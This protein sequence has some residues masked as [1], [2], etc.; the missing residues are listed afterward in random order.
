MSVSLVYLG[1]NDDDGEMDKMCKAIAKKLTHVGI[2]VQETNSG[3]KDL[4]SDN[5]VTYDRVWFCGHSR[6]VEATMSI[7]KNDDRTLGGFP[8][9][10]IAKFVKSCITRGKNKIRLICC[11]SAQQQR[12]RPTKVGAPPNGFAR[13]LGNELLQSVTNLKLLNYFTT[14]VDARVSHLE[15]LILAMAKLWQED[16]KT[17]QPAFEISGLWGAGDITDDYVPITAFLQD[18]GSLEAQ[19]K[20]NDTKVKTMNQ[21]TFAALFDN[22]HCSKND[23]PDFFGYSIR[24]NFLVEWAVLPAEQKTLRVVQ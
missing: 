4:P 5:S 12:Y 9:V 14:D 17:P 22:A 18:K 6:F 23:L 19:E 7:R 16:K 8:I 3:I 1:K 11:E 21:K 24:R 20:M 13:V 15:G 10:D 2:Q